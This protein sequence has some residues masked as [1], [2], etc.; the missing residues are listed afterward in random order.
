MTPIPQRKGTH[1]GEVHLMIQGNCSFGRPRFIVLFER[2]LLKS[3]KLLV[4]LRSEERRSISQ[5]IC[6]SYPAK[7]VHKEQTFAPT[8]FYF[9]SSITHPAHR[10]HESSALVVRGFVHQDVAYCARRFEPCPAP[11]FVL[12][13]GFFYHFFTIFVPHVRCSRRSFAAWGRLVVGAC[14]RKKF[15]QSAI[16]RISRPCVILLLGF[17]KGFHGEPSC[18]AVQRTPP[19]IAAFC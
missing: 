2:E 8:W 18:T 12:S 5:S 19:S 4:S 16:A 11:Y 14:L 13:N 10:L 15:N 6:V 7:R 3:E 17:F 9:V 1:A